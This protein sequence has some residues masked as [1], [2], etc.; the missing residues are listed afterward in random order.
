M[1]FVRIIA[2]CLLFA[3]LPACAASW[4]AEGGNAGG[5]SLEDLSGRT[6][7]LVSMDGE[8]FDGDE[9]PELGFTKEGRVVGSACNRF[10]GMAKIEGG[11]LTAKNVASTRMACIHSFL[12]AL[13]H[14][15]FD[16][17]QHGAHVR[18]DGRLLTLTKDGHIL[19]YVLPSPN[20]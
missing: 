4:R 11:M 12:N 16:M 7:Y 6:Y 3:T 17:L 18:L 15:L 1:F 19:M 14:T 10:S 8:S 9:T 2:C 20:L 13:E 5:L